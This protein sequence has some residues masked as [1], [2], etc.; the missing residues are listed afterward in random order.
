MIRAPHAPGAP[1][2][3]LQQ[4]QGRG[5][6]PGGCTGGVVVGQ[7]G[8]ERRGQGSPPEEPPGVHVA[9]SGAPREWCA[10]GSRVVLGQLQD[11]APRDP[12]LG[13]DLALAQVRRQGL[14]LHQHLARG[15]GRAREEREE[16]QHVECLDDR[17][18]K[19]ANRTPELSR[20]PE[21]RLQRCALQRPALLGSSGGRIQGGALDGE[22]HIRRG[23]LA[24]RGASLGELLPVVQQFLRRLPLLLRHLAPALLLHRGGGRGLDQVGEAEQPARQQEEASGEANLFDSGLLRILQG[25]A[26]AMPTL[27][28]PAERQLS[29]LADLQQA[30]RQASGREQRG[31]VGQRGRTEVPRQGEAVQDI[32]GEPIEL[33]L[34]LSEELRTGRVRR[35]SAHFH[36]LCVLCGR[37][38]GRRC[39]GRG[40]SRCS[41]RHAT[42]HAPA[43]PALRPP[44]HRHGSLRGAPRPGGRG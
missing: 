23:E 25:L 36:I 27:A 22:G 5:A 11:V 26:G 29:G 14:R 17:A 8:I 40:C 4:S 32:N 41:R 39:H 18:V 6:M 13:C 33:F 21:E 37:T 1:L 42:Q 7:R 16:R 3:R 30:I 24:H 20:A 35:Q 10:R 19:L 9:Q 31:A 34:D 28:R 44:R 43:A 12:A 15:R 2:E 38:D